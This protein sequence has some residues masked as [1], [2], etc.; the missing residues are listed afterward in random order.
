MSN[1]LPNGWSLEL[2][3]DVTQEIGDGG[4]PS[5]SKPEYFGGSIPWVVIDDITR[6]I[7]KTRQTIT[8][9]GLAK[10]SAKIWKPGTLILSTGAT[11]GE[12]GIAQVPLTTKQG[13][14]GIVCKANLSVEYLYQF[15][16]NSR[17]LLNSLAQGSTIKEVRAPTLKKI[18]IQIP[19]RAEQQKIAAIL[20]AVDDVIESTKAQINKLKDL[21]A[22]MMQELLTKGLGHT[23][24]KDS[25]IGRMPKS[26]EFKAIEDICKMTSG[27]T[28]DRTI[29]A[30]WNGK[31]PWVKTGEINYT[32]I[33]SSEEY[34]TEAGLKNSSTKLIPAGSVLMAMYGQG[35]TRGK[36]AILGIDACL[37]QA[38][39][40]MLPSS[41]IDKYFLFYFFTKEYENLRLLVQEGTQKNLNATIVKEVLVPL[42]PLEEQIQIRMRLQAID[43]NINL[44]KKRMQIATDLKKSLM[45]DLLTGKVRVQVD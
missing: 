10:S 11:I 37:N 25:P 32:T 20:T 28:P 12:V 17:S 15:F 34:I 23:E 30:Y 39:L 6:K 22:G 5:T 8:E 40:A 1:F 44:K 41:Q 4:T 2:L 29:A 43:D 38:C 33:F 26:W 21:K 3:G 31:I 9:L 24:F 35:I 18:P 13:I 16:L 45:Q 7:F 42:P 36:V 27:G 14:N 19:P